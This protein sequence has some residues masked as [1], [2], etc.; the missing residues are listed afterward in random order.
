MPELPEVETTR[1][2]IE[3]H[4]IGK[5]VTQLCVR[6]AAL[7]WPVPVDLPQQLVGQQVRSVNRRGK[8]LLIEFKRGH[9]L[10]H[11]GMSGSLRLV[12]PDEPPGFHD[13][14]DLHVGRDLCLRYT[15]PRRFGCWLWANGDVHAHPLLSALGPEPLSVDFTADYLFQSSRGRK[16]NLKTFIMDSHRVVGVGNIYA[17]EALFLAGLRPRRAA[18]NLSRLQATSLVR[19]IKEVL[20]RAIEMGG[21]TLK[22]FVGGDGKPGYFQQQLFVYGRGGEACRICHSLLKEVRVNNRATVYCA[23]CQR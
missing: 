1:R 17:N 13:H 21:T 22:D 8:Y 16:Q 19:H 7:R 23:N 12:K 14:V 2:G 11:L 20:A 9:L 15:D 5:K 4:I 6:N 10:I 3:P 18:G